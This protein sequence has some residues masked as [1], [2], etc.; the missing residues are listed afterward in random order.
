LHIGWQEPDE[1]DP[2]GEGKAVMVGHDFEFFA[3]EVRA[4]GAWDALLQEAA[5]AFRQA[6]LFGD[7]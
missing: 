5:S 6:G 4:Y 7:E 1:D 3:E 2:N